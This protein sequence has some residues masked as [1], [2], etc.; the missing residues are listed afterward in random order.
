MASSRFTPITNKRA[1]FDFEL[2]DRYVAGLQLLGSEIKSIRDG[3][4]NLID[5]FCAFEHGEL[6]VRNLHIAEYT[7]AN[8]M[9]HETKR[10]RKLLLKKGE[11]RKLEAKVKEKGFT[12]VPV[13][14]FLSER[15]F[16]KLEI[17]LARGKRTHDKRS[18]IRE[19]DVARDMDREKARF[20]R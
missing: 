2:L 3:K 4:A 9:N 15:G 10:A 14:L 5:A 12:I 7:W 8:R 20:K 17:A 6:W 1:R 11:L 16:A 18:T 19:R 13:K